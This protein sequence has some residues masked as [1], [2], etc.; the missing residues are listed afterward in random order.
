MS[1]AARAVASA[2]LLLDH[3]DVD[4]ACNRAYYAMFDAAK[5]ALMGLVPGSD[6]ALTKTHSGLISAFGLQLVRTGRLPIA[7]GKSLNRAHEIRQIADY[8]G[9]EVSAGHAK[10]L[11]EQADVFVNSIDASIQAASSGGSQPT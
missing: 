9:D 4:G 2:R 8:T 6:P 1:K 11:I 3:G 10:A 5:A 7:L